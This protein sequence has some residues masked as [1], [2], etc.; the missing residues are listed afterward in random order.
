M[1]KDTLEPARQFNRRIGVGNPAH[2][3]RTA[4]K[5]ISSPTVLAVEDEV[6]VCKRLGVTH[7]ISYQSKQSGNSKDYR[8]VHYVRRVPNRRK[9]FDEV[10][11]GTEVGFVE[12]MRDFPKALLDDDNY[13]IVDMT[14][15]SWR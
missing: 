4:Y 7:K 15:A 11:L 14:T 2:A 1:S 10:L 9:Y 3:I 5:A 8:S 13:S 6:K 12:V